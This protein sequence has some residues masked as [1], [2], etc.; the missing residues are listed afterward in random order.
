M[1]EELDNADIDEALAW[2]RNFV[3]KRWREDDE[4]FSIANSAIAMA[5]QSWDPHRSEWMQ[6]AKYAVIRACQHSY[7]AN[8]TRRRHEK[9]YRQ[10]V[11]HQ[12]YDPLDLP[13]EL[14]AVLDLRI[15][16]GMSERQ[17]AKALDIKPRDVYRYLERARKELF[18]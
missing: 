2:A 14:V 5:C 11:N 6:H 1:N 8:K 17:I 10:P 3:N 18:S 13:D 9:N 15:V 7:E 16:Y 12:L 4:F